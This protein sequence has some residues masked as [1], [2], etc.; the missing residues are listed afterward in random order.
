MT[1]I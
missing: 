1:G